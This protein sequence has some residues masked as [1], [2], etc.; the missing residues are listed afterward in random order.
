MSFFILLR[1]LLAF[2]FY[3]ISGTL[4]YR[5][6]SEKIPRF[7]TNSKPFCNILRK[8]HETFKDF[9]ELYGT[10]KV[11]YDIVKWFRI[12]YKS[13]NLFIFHT[14][15]RT[16]QVLFVLSCR[17]QDKHVIFNFLLNAS[18]ILPNFIKIILLFFNNI[19]YFTLS[20]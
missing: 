2:E 20:K 14:E 18:H 19:F 10:A 12:C 13:R 17:S 5:T 4:R 3:Y 8:F 6:E 7:A 15:T 16:G 9:V 1:Y 11:S